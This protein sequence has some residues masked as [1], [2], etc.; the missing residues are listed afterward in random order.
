MSY[1]ESVSLMESWL[2]WRSCSLAR[3][4]AQVKRLRGLRDWGVKHH[5]DANVLWRN[6]FGHFEKRHP[7]FWWSFFL[8]FFSISNGENKRLQAKVLVWSENFRRLSFAGVAISTLLKTL[9]I[10]NY[11]L[12]SFDKI[13]FLGY[14]FLTRLCFSKERK[15][16]YLNK[17]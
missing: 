11:I 2:S 3:I 6:N 4:Q 1:Q 8:F 7:P 14:N 16:C 9:S 13:H 17:I 10:N 15:L 12:L 5:L